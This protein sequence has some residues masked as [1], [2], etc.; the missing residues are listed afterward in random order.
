MNRTSKSLPAGCTL[1]ALALL[2][3]ACGPAADPVPAAGAG[4]SGGTVVAPDQPTTL[5]ADPPADPPAITPTDPPADPPTVTPTDPPAVPPAA[6]PAL[7]LGF[8]AELPAGAYAPASEAAIADTPSLWVVADWSGVTADQSE[9]LVL[10]SPEGSVY[11]ALEIPLA[12]TDTSLV[13]VAALADGTRRAAFQLLVWGTTIQS[14]DDV[15][16]WTAQATL[17]GGT[18][19]GQ[20]T[21]VL[22]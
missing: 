22:R 8:A 7:A 20:A 3:A 9:R 17:T 15:G 11:Y 5:P 14:Y 16:T 10:F 19:A 13:H 12:D 4:G 18:V 6:G 21:V 1:A 2:L